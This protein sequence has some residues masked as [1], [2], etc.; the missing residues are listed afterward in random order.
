MTTTATPTTQSTEEYN[1]WTNRET[2]AAALHLSNDESLYQAV[3]ELLDPDGAKWSNG[4]RIEA[5]VTTNV[6]RQLFPQPGDEPD[7]WGQL[8]RSMI[9]DVGSFWRVDWPAVAESFEEGS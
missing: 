8:W 9:S 2:W 3:L 6:E 1:G 4:D 7:P 5:F